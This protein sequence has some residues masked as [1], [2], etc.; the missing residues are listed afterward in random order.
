[1][2]E[3]VSGKYIAANRDSTGGKGSPPPPKIDLR[4]AEAM[5]REMAALYRDM[6][7]GR[8]DPQNGTRLAYVLNMLRQAYET[9]V[10]QKR[11]EA[12]ERMLPDFSG[13]AD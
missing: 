2:T 11:L 6:R 7:A 12:L 10:L 5:R 8:I 4:N 1:M 3:P 13:R 9:D